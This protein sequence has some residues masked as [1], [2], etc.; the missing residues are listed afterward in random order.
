[1]MDKSITYNCIKF[2]ILKAMKKYFPFFFTTDLK[3]KVPENL[4]TGI[5]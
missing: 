5:K 4:S 2:Q 3:Q 1:M